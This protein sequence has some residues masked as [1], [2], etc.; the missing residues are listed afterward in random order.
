MQW[1]SIGI[2]IG[3]IVGGI[4]LSAAAGVIE[5]IE[6]A[7]TLEFEETPLSLSGLAL[8]R[9]RV[10]FRGY[11][12]GLY[13]TPGT[14]P[15]RALDD[16]AKRLELEYFWPIDGKAIADAGDTLLRRNVAPEVWRKLLPRVQKINA[17]YQDVE[18][19]D[20]YSL[21]YIPGF[22]TELAKNNRRL[23]VIPGADFARAY[24]AIWLGTNPIDTS[25]RDQLF[26]GR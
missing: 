22:G 11:V 17:L 20:R 19:G 26:Q 10:I 14:P 9:Y 5:D 4:S 21:T 3:L 15:T 7:E 18:P 12:A 1:R 6:F 24:F 25:F 23:G 16:V 13:L 2:V 8:L